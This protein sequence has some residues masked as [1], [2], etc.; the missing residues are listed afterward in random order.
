MIKEYQINVA[1]KTVNGADLATGWVLSVKAVSKEDVKYILVIQT[2]SA[3]GVPPISDHYE[4]IV[5][6]I[7]EYIYNPSADNSK[8]EN[9]M[10]TNNLEADLDTWFGSTNWVVL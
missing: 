6:G 1:A 10:L 3:Q 8:S 2:C 9:L 4:N 7:K 5:G